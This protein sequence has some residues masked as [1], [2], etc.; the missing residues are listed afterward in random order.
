MPFNVDDIG[1]NAL[2]E[3]APISATASITVQPKS[4]APKENL[5]QKN[6]SLVVYTVLGLQHFEHAPRCYN[7]LG[8]NCL[9]LVC[10]YCGK[11]MYR[12]FYDG[13]CDVTIEPYSLRSSTRKFLKQ[14]TKTSIF[15][16]MYPLV[17]R[18]SIQLLANTQFRTI[19]SSSFATSQYL[20]AHLSL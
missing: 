17:A 2:Q 3:D 11:H 20:S 10:S 7:I 19:N 6:R 4:S 9:S 12:L 13:H 16:I 18:Q 5:R 14:R 15:G 1:L 8:K